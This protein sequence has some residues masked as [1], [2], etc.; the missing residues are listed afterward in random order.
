MISRAIKDKTGY[1]TLWS[2]HQ[3][4]RSKDLSHLISEEEPSASHVRQ[5]QFTHIW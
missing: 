4:S 5:D 2:R 3:S 1:V